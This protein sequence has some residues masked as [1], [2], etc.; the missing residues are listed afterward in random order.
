MAV[1]EISKSIKKSCGKI[2]SAGVKSIALATY[3]S[4]NVM[5]KF[6]TGTE[7]SPS[8][9]GIDGKINATSLESWLGDDIQFYEVEVA[10][11]TASAQ[12]TVSVGNTPDAKSI[13]HTVTGFLSGS[14]LS[15]AATGGVDIIGDNILPFVLSD[16]VIAVLYNN[17]DIK[18][19]GTT[20]G[21]SCTQFDEATGT[22]STD[23]IGYTFNYT[24]TQGVFPIV[25]DSIT[26]DMVM[27]N[28]PD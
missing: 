26:W 10:R 17:G 22:A 6:A 11:E 18:F 7:A 24:G 2:N 8:T 5:D 12:S 16:V 13:T 27:G 25:G 19:Y 1:C 4:T 14:I 28:F 23:Q 20:N 15:S 21:L 9:V 3:V